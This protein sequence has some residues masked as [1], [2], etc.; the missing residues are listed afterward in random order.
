MPWMLV[1]S[2]KKSEVSAM[3]R[4]TESESQVVSAGAASS[5]AAHDTR[6]AAVNE[7]SRPSHRPEP[8]VYAKPEP[9]EYPSAV[10]VAGKAGY[11]TSPYNEKIIDVTGIPPGTLV[12]DPT[13]PLEEKKYFRTPPE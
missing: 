13:F 12:A 11:V 5:R 7:R 3:P 1:C 4:P 9:D 8:K 10:R 6:E 2:C